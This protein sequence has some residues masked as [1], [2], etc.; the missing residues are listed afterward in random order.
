LLKAHSAE[1][2]ARG[3]AAEKTFM[4]QL[5]EEID[6]YERLLRGDLGEIQNLYGLG[7]MLIGLRIARG[8]TQR[9]LSEMMGVHESQVSRDERNEYHGITLERVQRLLDVMGVTLST[10]VQAPLLSAVKAVGEESSP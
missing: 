9:Q 2:V 5:A 4:L 10:R 1:E 6:S 7:R 8:I 3:M